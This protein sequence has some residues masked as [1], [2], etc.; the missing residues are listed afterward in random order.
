MRLGHMSEIGLAELSKRGLLDGYS[1]GKLKFCEHCVFGKHKRVRFNTSV[2][3]TEGFWIMCILI[4]GGHL[5][6]HR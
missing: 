2:H 1:I 4:Y 3:T 5:G 6:R